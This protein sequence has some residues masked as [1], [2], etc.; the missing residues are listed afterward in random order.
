LILLA[1]GGALYTIGVVFH[2]W[3]RLPFQTAIWHLFVVAAAA[4]HYAAVVVSMASASPP[5]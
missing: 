3:E 5:V 1:T 2:V 4:V